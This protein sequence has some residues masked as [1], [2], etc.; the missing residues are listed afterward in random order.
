MLYGIMNQVKFGINRFMRSESGE[1]N[2]VSI[3]VLIGIA[4]ALALLFKGS[5]T[6]LLKSLLASITDSANDAMK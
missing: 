1:V 6:T 5:I 2:V 4:V 3:V